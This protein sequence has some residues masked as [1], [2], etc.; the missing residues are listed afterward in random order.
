MSVVDRFDSRVGG[1]GHPVPN[2]PFT[3]RPVCGSVR[4]ACRLMV[5]RSGAPHFGTGFAAGKDRQSPWSPCRTRNGA[6][7][8]STVGARGNGFRSLTQRPGRPRSQR[9]PAQVRG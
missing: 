4:M 5:L 8:E 9:E 1:L 3:A 2:P 7:R 6:K